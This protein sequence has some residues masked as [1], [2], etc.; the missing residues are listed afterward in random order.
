MVAS[1]PAECLNLM[2]GGIAICSGYSL[3]SELVFQMVNH[4]INMILIIYKSNLKI[5]LNFHFEIW[6]ILQFLLK[7]RKRKIEMSKSCMIFFSWK[8]IVFFPLSLSLSLYIYISPPPS[9]VAFH[10]VQSSLSDSFVQL[11][12][13]VLFINDKLA[14]QRASHVYSEAKRVHAFKDTVASDLR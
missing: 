8:Y 11:W 14:F 12:F 5:L 10:V 4:F 3:F 9:L 6:F 1:E 2:R 13:K 7:Y